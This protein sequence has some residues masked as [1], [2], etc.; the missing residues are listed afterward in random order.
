MD[1]LPELPFEKVLSYLSL[2]DRLKARAVS[3]GWYHR[4]N[5]CG[6]KSLC[7]SKRPV[8][9]VFEKSRWVS[10]AFAQN[11]ISSNRF[12]SFFDIFGQT[13]LANLKHLRLIDLTVENGKVLS[14]ALNSFGQLKELDMIRFNHPID[15]HFNRLLTFELNLPMLTGIQLN[16]M[17]GLYT[18]ILKA[19]RLKK[20]KLCARYG[21]L[22][23]DLVHQQSVEWLL[24]DE[25]SQL[26][27]ESLKDFKNL[28]HLYCRRSTPTLS[29][30]LNLANLNQLKEIHLFSNLLSARDHD[31]AKLKNSIQLL[32]EQK[33]Q[34][35]RADLKIY[36]L[37]CLLDGPRDPAIDF[38]LESTHTEA[39][40]NYFD[41]LAKKHPQV[42][43]EIPF[44]G[45]LDYSSIEK[46][47]PELSIDLV[48][49]EIAFDLVNKL[50]D[51]NEIYV[52]TPLQ[53]IK[54]EIILR[55]ILKSSP[56]IVALE[57]W[58]DL[59]QSLFDRLPAFSAIQKIDIHCPVD[60]MEFL[61][62]LK[63]L[64]DLRLDWSV[65]IQTIRRAFDE[66]PFLSLFESK[67]DY[68][69]YYDW[70]SVRVAIADPTGFK[71]LAGSKQANVPDL[72]AAV[73]FIDLSFRKP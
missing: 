26:V 49:P 18:L 62:Q 40:L 14:K 13:I 55:Q 3:R 31:F 22:A 27:G 15:S 66:L 59:S 70:Y 53:S 39:L 25:L 41:F 28:K 17:R 73:S 58:G 43:D 9:F 50:T 60:N 57:F 19:P 29:S 46:I 37:G 1:D 23:V 72:N 48:V 56:N 52:Y 8:G 67:Y 30:S 65:G 68:Y 69:D 12:A 61:F 16:D 24:I 20:V 47:V 32:F 11:F 71:V 6:V 10:D 36:L 5:N 63:H 7:F 45:Q 2:K 42:A 38:F 64:I 54:T 4:I 51:L 21:S 35:R 44:N 34:Y 33:Q